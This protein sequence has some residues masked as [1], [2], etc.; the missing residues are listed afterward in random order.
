MSFSYSREY[1]DYIFKFPSINNV[2]VAEVI[3]AEGV[4]LF[5]CCQ[6]IVC[7][8][9]VLWFSVISYKSYINCV[10]SLLFFCLFLV[11]DVNFFYF[12]Y[13]L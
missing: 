9:S 10:L 4:S 5:L 8:V 3:Y 2:K 12:E 7:S 13:S 6:L 11:S 1:K